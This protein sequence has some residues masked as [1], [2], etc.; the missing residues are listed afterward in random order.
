MTAYT[1]AP[2]AQRSFDGPKRQRTF[3]A[4]IA[5]LVDLEKP[6]DVLHTLR[7]LEG[8]GKR[9]VDTIRRVVMRD[10]TEA[11]VVFQ[12]NPVQGPNDPMVRVFCAYMLAVAAE[13]MPLH[14]GKSWRAFSR[15][16]FRGKQHREVMT[17]DGELE[18]E[19]VPAAS[20]GGLAGRLG[21]CVRTLDLYS[22][23]A[24]AAGFFAVRQIRKKESVDKLPRHLRGVK[25]SYA[26]H[27]WLMAVPRA[28]ADRVRGIAR[29]ANVET[30]PPP[31][32]TPPTAAEAAE[33][34][35][36]AAEVLQRLKR[37][38]TPPS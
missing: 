3:D 38:A 24:R 11:D 17:P 23:I 32:T 37:A 8:I 31:R 12:P 15:Y 25:Y 1:T 30:A 14:G 13:C 29:A 20:Q 10:V 26:V 35:A 18:R 19:Y 7:E 22:R 27:E 9:W 34:D 16:L 33:A 5:R 2:L 36:Y 6:C 4:E 21:V 28:I